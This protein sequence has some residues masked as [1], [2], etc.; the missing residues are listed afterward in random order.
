MP[1]VGLFLVSVS[2]PWLSLGKGGGRGI[3]AG[4]LWSP[5]GAVLLLRA[6]SLQHELVDRPWYRRTSESKAR[7]PLLSHA[8]YLQYQD[9][10]LSVK[11][12]LT[13]VRAKAQAHESASFSP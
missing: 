6:C 9:T 4:G 12:W 3:G 1:G 7:A 8:F 13:D 5:A 2:V 10:E 11:A